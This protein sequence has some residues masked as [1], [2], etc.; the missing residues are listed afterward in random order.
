[1]PEAFSFTPAL[2]QVL[3]RGKGI[4]LLGPGPVE[5]H[6]EHAQRFARAVG[7]APATLLDLGSG[8]GIPGLFLSLLWPST[9]VLLVDAMARRTTFLSQ[10]TADLEISDRCQVI[11]GRAEDLGQASEYRH[12]FEVVTARS[13]GSP[14]VT[15]ECATG[16]LMAGGRLVV[17]EPPTG[18]KRWP[19]A[20]LESLGLRYERP[21]EPF[22]AVLRQEVVCPAHYPRRPGIPAKRPLW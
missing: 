19:S 10:S 14:A 8:G 12:H 18:E 6:I 9:L 4:G 22:M 2:A 1:V 5:D 3:E 16:F 20:A 17:S 7:P 21:D 11:Q 15:A 13:F